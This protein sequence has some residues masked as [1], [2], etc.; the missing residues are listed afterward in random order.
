MTGVTMWGLSGPVADDMG[1]NRWKKGGAEE[2]F[3]DVEAMYN[4]ASHNRGVKIRKSDG[5][6]AVR[7]V[8]NGSWR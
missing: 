4:I 3:V 6:T 2:C 8:R 5:G 1:L 7:S